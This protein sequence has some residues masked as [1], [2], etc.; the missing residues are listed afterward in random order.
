MVR[1]DED[2]ETDSRAPEGGEGEK[3]I[4]GAGVMMPLRL[5]DLEICFP[6]N[7]AGSCKGKRQEYFTSCMLLRR[8]TIALIVG[9]SDGSFR[10]HLCAMSATILDALDGKR[11]F[12]WGS[13]IRD[14]RQSSVRKGRLHLTKFRSSLG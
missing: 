4:L 8:S 5:G 3:L 11:P 14:S 6:E 2:G 10:R 1:L 13:I 12:S 7:D 9:L